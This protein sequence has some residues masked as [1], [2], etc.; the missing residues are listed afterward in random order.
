[1]GITDGLT[2]VAS[3]ISNQVEKAS[4]H[5]LVRPARAFERSTNDSSDLVLVPLNIEA[6]FAQEFVIKR[7]KVG[8]YEDAFLSYIPIEEEQGEALILSDT[9]V[10]WR[11]RKSLWGRT[12]ANISHCFFMLDSVG[13]ML[14]GGEVEAVMIPCGTNACALRVYS[15]LAYNAHRMGFPSHVIPVDL[16]SQDR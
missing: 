11:Q 4:V 16:L 5:V 15:A 3:G 13:I 7:A 6:A 14:Y 8:G 10:Y 1:M 12:W 9:Y 2:S